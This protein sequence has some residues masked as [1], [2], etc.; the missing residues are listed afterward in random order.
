MKKR[1]F[2]VISAVTAL[3]I[4]LSP[5]SGLATRAANDSRIKIDVTGTY[6]QTTARKMLEDINAFRTGNDAWYWNESNTEKVQCKDLKAL[7]YDYELEKTA[8][9]RAME[10]AVYFSHERP[11]GTDCF[12]AFSPTNGFV[13]ENLAFGYFSAEEAFK[14]W[15]ETNNPFVGQG[16]RRSM[17]D[18]CFTCVA[19]GHVVRDGVDYWVQEFRSVNLQKTATNVTNATKN[20]NVEFLLSKLKYKATPSSIRMKY[21][22]NYDLSNVKESL[23]CENDIDFRSEKPSIITKPIDNFS[24]SDSNVLKVDGST[25]K[26]V[27]AGSANLTG[28]LSDRTTYSIPVNVNA[29]SLSGATVSS[30][31][32]QEYTGSS[33]TPAFTVTLNGKTLVENTDYTVEYSNNVNEGYGKITITGKGNYSGTKTTSFVI[34]KK[35]TTGNNSQVI[36]RNQGYNDGSQSGFVEDGSDESDLKEKKSVTATKVKSFSLTKGKKCLTVKWSKV[37]DVSGYEIQYANSKSMDGAKIKSAK[38]SKSSLKIKKLKSG[39]KYYVRIRSYKKD[40]EVKVYSAWSKIKKVK[41]K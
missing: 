7:E 4:G 10:I 33:I 28:L 36:F 23:Y 8:M 32:Y 25:L 39:K 9:Q 37:S 1:I 27:A 21:G 40:G 34:L 12:T 3:V 35:C 6:E 41:V 17:L 26:G 2:A 24:V 15:Q 19:I 14:G 13:G 5:I 31:G 38:V 18:P 29:V 22:D 30:I 16:H 11:N 20:V